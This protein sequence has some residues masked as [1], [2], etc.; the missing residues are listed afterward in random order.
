MLVEW[1]GKSN[2]FLFLGYVFTVFYFWTC[3][4]FS[5]LLLSRG[6]VNVFPKPRFPD[7]LIRCTLAGFKIQQQCFSLYSRSDTAKNRVYRRENRCFSVNFTLKTKKYLTKNIAKA[8]KCRL[9]WIGINVS[10]WNQR[11]VLEIYFIHVWIVIILLSRSNLVFT[12]KTPPIYMLMTYKFKMSSNYLQSTNN[13][14]L[15]TVQT[16]KH[17]S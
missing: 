16:P 4:V 2:F 7:T 9:L 10:R 8:F 13:S 15:I 1:K 12:P 11:L 3:A 17:V 14:D 6:C 5:F